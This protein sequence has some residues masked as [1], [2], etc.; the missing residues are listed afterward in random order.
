[1]TSLEAALKPPVAD[2]MIGFKKGYQNSQLFS[3]VLGVRYR[4]S[5]YF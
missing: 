2:L 1:M 4:R 3:M 5:A